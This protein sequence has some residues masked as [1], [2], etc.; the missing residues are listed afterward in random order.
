MRP[1]FEKMRLFR[2]FGVVLRHFSD[3]DFFGFCN[4]RK[5]NET[6]IKILEIGTFRACGQFLG[7]SEVL[8][9][10]KK[11]LASSLVVELFGH[12]N[13]EISQKLQKVNEISQILENLAIF[14]LFLSTKKSKKFTVTYNYILHGTKFIVVQFCGRNSIIWV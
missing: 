4:P 14:Q 12:A 3:K 8:Y 6:C 11:L 13:P 5:L 1:I 7:H 9:L 10:R 2:I